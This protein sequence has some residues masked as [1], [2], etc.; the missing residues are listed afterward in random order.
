LGIFNFFLGYNFNPYN[1][2]LLKSIFKKGAQM[3]KIA[4]FLI[5]PLLLL[6]ILGC[7]PLIVGA[8]VGAVGGYAA[9]K[10]T[11]QGETDRSFDS[12]WNSALMVS[13]IR[14][15]VQQEDYAGG[16]IIVD[17][18]P[19]KVWIRLVR[20]TQATTRI[21]VSARKYHMPNLELAQDLYVK[22]MEQAQ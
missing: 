14:G 18:K 13:K 9:S 22:I 21:R 5:S 17:V 6:N 11:I 4:F 16:Q 20:L 15:L 10:D 19:T 1:C 7:A 12:L 3:K 8:A 2:L